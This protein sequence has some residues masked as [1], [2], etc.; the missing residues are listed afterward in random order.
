MQMVKR[1]MANVSIYWN[2]EIRIFFSTRYQFYCACM[3]QF[4]CTV[5][6]RV[7]VSVFCCFIQLTFIEVISPKMTL[8]TF[9]Y[10][11]KRT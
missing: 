11:M 5:R 4:V 1:M 8:H 7:R 3:R 6:V 10:E 9:S 2:K